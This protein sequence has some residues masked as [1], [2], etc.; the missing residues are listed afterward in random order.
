MDASLSEVSA[1]TEKFLTL[2]KQIEAIEE[3]QIKPLSDEVMQIQGKLIPLLEEIWRAD[4]QNLDKNGE[5]KTRPKFC[6]PAGSIAVEKR[7]SLAM[8]DGDDKI[9][10]VAFM[11]EIGEWDAFATIHHAKLTSWFKEKV[12]NNPIFAAPGLGLPKEN[13]YLKRGK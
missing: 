9:A 3:D 12:E 1:L 6:S 7:I 10:F 11:K 4:P 8:P 13:K 2:K 5:F